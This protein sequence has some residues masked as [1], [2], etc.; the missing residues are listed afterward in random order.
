[1]RTSSNEGDEPMQQR[2]ENPDVWCVDSPMTPDDVY[3]EVLTLKT[4]SKFD[5]LF[6]ELGKR[7]KG[8]K[9]FSIIQ[10]R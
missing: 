8:I 5:G 10:Q 4:M 9:G 2:E 6:E 7:S 1:M 3:A